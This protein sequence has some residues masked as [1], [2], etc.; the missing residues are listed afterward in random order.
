MTQSNTVSSSVEVAADPDLAFAVFTDEIDL[1]WVRGPIN[2]FD[3]ARAVG[4]RCE[5]GVGG[6]LL[7]VYDDSTGDV[8]ELA[9]ITAWEPG[10]RL[11]WSSSVDDV[12]VEIRFDPTAVGTRVRVD[13]TIPPKS[14]DRGGTAWVRTVP[15]F[16]GA[17]FARRDHAPRV[18]QER[19]RLAVEVHYDRPAETARWLV[20]AFGLN[21]VMPLPDAE[22]PYLWIEFLVGDASLILLSAEG[23][24][25]GAPT[26]VP[27]I[28][29]DDLDAH[30]AR[31]KAHGAVIVED[32]QQHGYRAYVAEDPEGHRWTIAQA[33]PTMT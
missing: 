2:F 4:M 11:A 6:R 18:P 33:R 10:V 32:I 16:L 12:E 5:P 31:S 7:E 14:E 25:E 27:W 30:L 13:A 9:R 8:L 3:A 22:T 23:V 26:H 24:S 15:S 20:A 19:G 17:W 1:W 28:H 29:V 21:S